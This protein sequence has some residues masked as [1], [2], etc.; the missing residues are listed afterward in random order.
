MYHF[1]FAQACLLKCVAVFSSVVYIRDYL[2][3]IRQRAPKLHY[4]LHSMKTVEQVISNIQR[5][6]AINFGCAERLLWLHPHEQQAP[7]LDT[8]RW[9]TSIFTS[10]AADNIKP[11]QLDCNIG[12]KFNMGLYL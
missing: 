12:Y 5:Q 2:L 11:A 1:C 4:N 10:Y 8:A 9:G 7:M 3:C 6:Y